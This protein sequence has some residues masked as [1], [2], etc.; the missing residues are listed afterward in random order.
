M[1]KKYR[2]RNNKDFQFT[3]RRGTSISNHLLVLIYRK[4]GKNNNR[5]GFSVSRKYGKAVHRNKI[6]RRLK[7]IYREQMDRLIEGYDMIFIVRKNARDADYWKLREWMQNLL[8]RAG[9]YREN[10]KNSK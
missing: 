8:N 10:P 6:K 2:L 9:L 7:E 4:T 3:Y 5:V 1:N